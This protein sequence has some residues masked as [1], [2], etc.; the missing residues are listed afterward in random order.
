[1]ARIKVSNEVGRKGKDVREGR[2][3]VVF[4]D[5]GDFGRAAPFRRVGIDDES[6]NEVI[7]RE[8]QQ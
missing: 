8:S 6:I 1:M 7:L 4:G 5:W 2:P 3:V